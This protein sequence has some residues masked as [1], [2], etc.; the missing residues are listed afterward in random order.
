MSDLDLAATNAMTTQLSIY[1]DGQC[2]LCLAEIHLLQQRNRRQLLAFFD[3]SDASVAS[4]LQQFSCAEALYAMHGVLSTGEVIRGVSV[5]A[6]AYKRADL[7]GL[8]WLLSI[9][10]LQG[11]YAWLYRLFAK[12]RHFISRIC[13]PLALKIAH[14]MNPKQ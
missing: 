2:P 13:G 1:Y 14:K 12:H 4:S 11:V 10:Q 7:P 9:R 5:F 8:S 6:E 3:V